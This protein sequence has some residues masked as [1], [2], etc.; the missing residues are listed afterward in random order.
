MDLRAAARYSTGLAQDANALAGLK[1][2]AKNDPQKALKSA[3]AQFEALFLQQLMK[4][5]RAALPDDG[6]TTSDAT[7]TYTEMLDAQ[8]AQT[9][10]KK[11]TDVVILEVGEILGIIEL[12][13]VVSAST[14]DEKYVPTRITQS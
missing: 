3:A 1:G 5:M 6:P 4:S 12:F 14:K 8:L 11:G 13:V 2:Q 10:A 9:L 7:K